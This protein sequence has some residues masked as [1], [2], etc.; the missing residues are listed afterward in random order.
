MSIQ[1]AIQSLWNDTMT[2]TIREQTKNAI[3]K[4]NEFVERDICVDVPCRLSYKDISNTGNTIGAAE[5][6]QV[7]KLFCASDLSIPPGS[8]I[9]VTRGGN[10]IDYTQSGQPAFYTYHQEIP[11]QLFERWA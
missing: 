6:Y 2:V 3:T 10:T 5:M 9:S 11:L 1:T 4:K 8:K 7:V